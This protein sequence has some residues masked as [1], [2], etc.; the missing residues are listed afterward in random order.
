MGPERL[1]FVVRVSA[2]LLA[3]LA[4][5]C[6]GSKS[7]SRAPD[8]SAAG[9]PHLQIV[10]ALTVPERR[11]LVDR[12]RERNH[13][14]PGTE[15]TVNE[16]ALARSVTVVDPFAGFLRRARRGAADRPSRTSAPVTEAEAPSFAREFVKQNADLLGLPRHVLPGL[17]EHVRGVEP[18]D[19]AA[20]RAR[21]A[22][23]F[24][25]S[26]PT[27]GY[28]SFE[29]ISCHA[30]IE[31]FVDDDGEVSSF[32]NL[33]RIH[34]HLTIDTRHPVLPQ[35][36]PRVASKLVGRKVF[37][38]DV[39][40][41]GFDG[42][43]DPRELPRIP[44]GEVQPGDVTRMQLVIHV[45]TGPRLAWLTYRLAYFVEVAKPVPDELVADDESASSPPQFFFFRWVVDADTG[46]VLEDARVPLS[47]PA[48]LAR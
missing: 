47:D 20:P 19:H 1:T 29:E 36:D 23:R 35:D 4:T 26:F 12:L 39:A 45:S 31:V 30:D 11:A 27:K 18:H 41:S 28:E 10:H 32:V 48:A 9:P 40:S 42:L 24:D 6:G 46:D 14:P 8:V 21:W 2:L 17:A 33:S 16:E 5:S 7:S 15:W 37:A 13:A 25:A 34:P 38:L 3:A 44:L 22:V 43:R